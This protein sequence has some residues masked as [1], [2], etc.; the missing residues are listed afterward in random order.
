MVA[1]SSAKSGRYEAF[2]EK[3]VQ[4]E[5][6]HA[7][8]LDGLNHSPSG[9][10]RLAATPNGTSAAMQA[11]WKAPML[12]GVS[13]RMVVRVD[14]EQNSGCGGERGAGDRTRE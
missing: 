4:P 11:V 10:A 7:D 12:E 6:E 13:G 2:V 1:R 3:G 8:D 5:R 14:H 9:R